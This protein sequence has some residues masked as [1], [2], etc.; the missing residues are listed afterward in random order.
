MKVGLQISRK[1][2]SVFLKLPTKSRSVKYQFTLRL[3]L[4]LSV[5][6][7]SVVGS[8]LSNES[9]LMYSLFDSFLIVTFQIAPALNR[10]NLH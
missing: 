10:I 9:Q 1:K 7:F 6:R 3:S 4:E 8:T 5:Y 2:N